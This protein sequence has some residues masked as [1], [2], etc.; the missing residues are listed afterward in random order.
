[1]S[2]WELLGWVASVC[3]AV[4][5]IGFSVFVLVAMALGLRRGQKK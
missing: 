5:L 3:L 4:V 2:A 1:M